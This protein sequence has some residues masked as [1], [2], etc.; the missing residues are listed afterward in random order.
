MQLSQPVGSDEQPLPTLHENDGHSDGSGHEL[1]PEHV[2]SH[3]HESAQRVRRLH[4]LW[5]EHVTS[6]LPVGHWISSP[7]AFVPSHWTSHETA[8]WQNT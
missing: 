5:P 8:Y 3:E 4:E 2:T 7:H 6:Q 1:V